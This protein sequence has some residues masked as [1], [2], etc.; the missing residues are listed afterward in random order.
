MSK[1]AAGVLRGAGR[2]LV[3]AEFENTKPSRKKSLNTFRLW[4]MRFCAKTTFEFITFLD[5]LSSGFQEA[6]IYVSYAWVC[7][8]GHCKETYTFAFA[9]LN[10]FRF[11]TKSKLFARILRILR[12]HLIMIA[13]SVSSSFLTDKTIYA[14]GTIHYSHDAADKSQ[15]VEYSEKQSIKN[16]CALYLSWVIIWHA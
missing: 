13:P 3:Y 5:K 7:G 14:I 15:T 16:V 6:T 10:R 8:I 12:R 11:S 4:N 1:N 2:L 9:V